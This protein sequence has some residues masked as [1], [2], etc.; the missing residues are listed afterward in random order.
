M[1]KILSTFTLFWLALLATACEADPYVGKRPIDYP[2]TTWLCEEPIYM[3]LIY[4]ENKNLE[5]GY[6]FSENSIE[7][8]L[9]YSSMDE[10]VIVLDDEGNVLFRCNAEYFDCECRLVVYETNHDDIEVGA[11]FV[12]TKQVVSYD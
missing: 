7:I 11:M 9:L 8:S 10:K 3:L 1:K 12:L 5:T 6:L 4:D 2:N